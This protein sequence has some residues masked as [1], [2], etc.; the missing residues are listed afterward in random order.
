MALVDNLFNIFNMN[1]LNDLFIHYGLDKQVLKLLLSSHPRCYEKFSPNSKE[2]KFA[3]HINGLFFYMI[4]TTVIK[5]SK[6]GIF[7]NSCEELLLTICIK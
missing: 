7:Q 1:K 4:E 5:D 2:S 3:R 6:R